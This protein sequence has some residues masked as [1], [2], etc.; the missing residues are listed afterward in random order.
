M[1]RIAL[2]S[3]LLVL[4]VF[5]ER[6][7]YACGHEGPYVG[8]A[9]TQLIQHTRDNRYIGSTSTTTAQKISWGSRYGT[10]VKFGYD[11]CG[12]RFG[13]EMPIGVNYQLLNNA[14]D[15]LVLNL[16]TNLIIH[17]IETEGGLDFYWIAGVGATVVTEGDID[18][19]SKAGGISGNFGPGV[20]YFFNQG[21]HRSAIGLSIPVKYTMYV[22]DNLSKDRTS[23]IGVPV[24]IGFTIG[25]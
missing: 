21:K 24:N 6:K 18:D 14:D 4:C 10:Q 3:L 22:G 1:K 8:L 12:T 25:F 7:L 17:I 19:N 16:D 23:V 11:F 5:G 9:Y 13:V 2:L 15:V 20:Q